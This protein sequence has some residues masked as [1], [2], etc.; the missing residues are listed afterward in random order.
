MI[1]I[2]VTYLVIPIVVMFVTFV[3]IT[4]TL[5]RVMEDEQ[6]GQ[7][8]IGEW[9]IKKR[10]IVKVDAHIATHSATRGRAAAEWCRVFLSTSFNF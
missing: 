8:L 5:R 7:Q 10:I 2:D 9:L 3:S 4:R 1:F 6:A